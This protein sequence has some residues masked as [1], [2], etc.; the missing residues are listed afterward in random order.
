MLLYDS[1]MSFISAFKNNMTEYLALDDILHNPLPV[2][3]INVE[4][5]QR[6]ECWS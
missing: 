5:F 3:K 4:R 1:P 2:T 6:N